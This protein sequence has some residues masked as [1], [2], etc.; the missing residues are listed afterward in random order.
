MS[1][2]PKLLAMLNCIPMMEAFNAEKFIEIL[3]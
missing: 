1:S 3:E 2:G